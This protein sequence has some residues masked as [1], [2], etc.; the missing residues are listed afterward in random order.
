MKMN[1]CIHTFIIA[2]RSFLLVSVSSPI[3]PSEAPPS[4]VTHLTLSVPLKMIRKTHFNRLSPVDLP[5]SH[6]RLFGILVGSF[7]SDGICDTPCGVRRC[8]AAPHTMVAAAAPDRQADGRER[9]QRHTNL[10]LTR[11]PIKLNSMDYVADG[12]FDSAQHAKQLLSSL[13]H[14]N[15]L[16]YTTCEHR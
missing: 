8:G 11:S 7:V 14:V 10:L 5:I 9:I 13:M 15:D 16:Q 1:P 6:Y 3:S 4:T 12:A 2:L